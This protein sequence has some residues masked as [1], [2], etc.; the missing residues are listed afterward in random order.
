MRCNNQP[1]DR[2]KSMSIAHVL[3]SA[4]FPLLPAFARPLLQRW[5]ASLQGNTLSDDK[6]HTR[7]CAA[8]LYARAAR[9]EATQPGFAADLRAAAEAMDRLAAQRPR[10][11]AAMP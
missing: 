9:Y 5:A 3:Q 7:D 4:T 11:S 1:L 8:M 10:G 2:D 6:H